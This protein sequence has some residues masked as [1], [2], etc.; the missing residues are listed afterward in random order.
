MVAWTVVWL[1]LLNGVVVAVAFGPRE[2]AAWSQEWWRSAWSGGAFQSAHHFNQS[3][4]A[5]L[6]R[7]L[8]EERTLLGRSNPVAVNLAAWPEPWIRAALATLGGVGLALLAW[9]FRRPLPLRDPR[10]AGEY[11]ILLAFAAVMS[12][13]AWKHHFVALLPLNAFAF[14]ALRALPDGARAKS[15]LWVAWWSTLG[16][17]TLT[18]PVFVGNRASDLFEVASAVTLGALTLIALGTIL[19]ARLPRDPHGAA[20]P[21]PRAAGEATA[22]GVAAGPRSA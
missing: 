1:L 5:A 7:L 11:A 10:A 19:L 6:K 16:L 21:L 13:I 15:A 4:Y 22:P 9:A 18:S 17:H 14:S 2:A 8:T 12:P 3:L 20:L